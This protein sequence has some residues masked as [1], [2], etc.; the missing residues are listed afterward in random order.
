MLYPQVFWALRDAKEKHRLELERLDDEHSS[1]LQARVA[2]AKEAIAAVL[3]GK[4][5]GSVGDESKSSASAEVPTFFVLRFNRLHPPKLDILIL[6]QCWYQCLTGA[7]GAAGESRSK[8][9]HQVSEDCC[10]GKQAI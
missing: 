9:D 10:P 3:R 5:E 2:R 8:S 6:S 4:Q 7:T 1:W